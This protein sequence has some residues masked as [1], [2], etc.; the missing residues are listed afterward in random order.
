MPQQTLRCNSSTITEGE[1]FYATSAILKRNLRTVKID[2]YLFNYHASI[3]DWRLLVWWAFRQN[4]EM[5]SP[6]PLRKCYKLQSCRATWEQSIVI[7]IL[8][9]HVLTWHGMVLPVRTLTD[10]FIWEAR[11]NEKRKRRR[12]KFTTRPHDC[13]HCCRLWPIKTLHPKQNLRQAPTCVQSQCL[14]NT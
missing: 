9:Q 11:K 8:N 6:Q 1:I 10:W 13:N 7:A 12:L 2:S 4:F 5:Q 3:Y 14:A